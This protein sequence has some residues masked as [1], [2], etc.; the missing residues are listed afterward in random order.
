VG[1]NQRGVPPVLGRH[2]ASYGLVLRGLGGGR[3]A[4]V[5]MAASGVHLAGD[6][7][8]MRLVRGG[9]AAGG[10]PRVVVA[11]NDDALV[12][13][14][15]TRAPARPA[16]ATLAARDS[17]AMPPAPPAPRPERR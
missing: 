8:R 11:R 15:A 17:R 5:E 13:L 14:R 4:P 1:G 7:R 9:S 6:V 10:A 3:F 16:P 12:L 2:D